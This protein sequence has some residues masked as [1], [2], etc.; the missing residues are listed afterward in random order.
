MTLFPGDGNTLRW[1]C[2]ESE[3]HS[4]TQWRAREEGERVGGRE[5]VRERVRERERER[6]RTKTTVDQ[7]LTMGP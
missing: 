6:E 7:L 5:G 2:G 4:I 1:L 3:S